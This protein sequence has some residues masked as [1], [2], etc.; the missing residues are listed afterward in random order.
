MK[1]GSVLRP[2]SVM[3]IA[4]ALNAVTLQAQ[5][6]G[7]SGSLPSYRPEQPVSG[8]IRIWGHGSRQQGLT[9]RLV[10]AW[11]EAFRKYQP[12]VSF[13]IQLLGDAPAIG[14]LYTGSADI[15]LMGREILPTELE[16]YQQALGHKPFE[17][18][19]MTGSADVG[20]LTLAP[21]IFVHKDNPLA[22][23]TLA[24]LDAIFGAD[25]RRGRKKIQVWGDL[26]LTGDWAD[27][28][29]RLYGYSLDQDVS[30][31]IEQAVLAGSEKWNC[32]LQEFSDLRKRNGSVTE[33]GQRILDALGQDRYGIAISSLVYKN[34]LTKPLAL[35]AQDGGEYYMVSQE[36][37]QARKYPLARAVFLFIDRPAKQPI[38]PK[39]KEFLRFLLSEEGQAAITAQGGYLPLTTDLV[40]QER[41][42]IE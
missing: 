29:V 15:A 5:Q 10:A 32:S 19:V 34:P 1:P 14:G 7:S 40:Q 27:K 20:N 4:I 39:L 33:A 37:V 8:T 22:Q 9:G 6:S 30:R 17:I 11:E 41:G 28:P 18:S 23:L 16:G 3:F 24:Q 13:D 25:Q 26:G 42:K 31:F 38:E 36:T 12:G 2:V 35:A 21:V